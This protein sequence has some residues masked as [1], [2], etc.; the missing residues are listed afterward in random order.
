MPQMIRQMTAFR[1]QGRFEL[2]ERFV[3]Q[4][5]RELVRPV[6]LNPGI[7]VDS[8]YRQCQPAEQIGNVEGPR[9]GINAVARHGGQVDAESVDGGGTVF[10]VRLPLEEG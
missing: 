3:A 6:V 10:R 8:E 2:T 9:A 5:L 7:S 4:F 1:E